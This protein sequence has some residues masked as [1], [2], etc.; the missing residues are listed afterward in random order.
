MKINSIAILGLSTL[1]SSSAVRS[2]NSFGNNDNNRK[3]LV[4]ED[5]RVTAF[6]NSDDGLKV[7]CW[8]IGDLL[9]HNQRPRTDASK[10]TV[11]QTSISFTDALLVSFPPAMLI[12]G[13]PDFM[14]TQERGS[15]DLLKQKHLITVKS[16]L[17]LARGIFRDSRSP[18]H[19]E[20]FIFSGGNGDDWFYF[21][22]RSTSEGEQCVETMDRRD[23]TIET[24]SGSDT[25][26]IDFAYD[27]TPR[28]RVI[29]EGRCE[30]AGLQ[31]VRHSRQVNAEKPRFRTQGRN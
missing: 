7:E 21:E 23:F 31:P 1:V 29:H 24:V 10:G 28:H 9:P 4:N 5:S 27:E 30:F 20:E 13:L 3:H 25:T 26:L 12:F 11:R 2:T 14:K 15:Y 22:D 16:G 17:V 8:E 19:E 18:G 6:I